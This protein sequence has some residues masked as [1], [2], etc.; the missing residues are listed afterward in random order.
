MKKKKSGLTEAKA[1]VNVEAGVSVPTDKNGTQIN[2]GDKVKI[3]NSK[4]DISEIGIVEF[5]EGELK[6]KH[7]NGKYS[8]VKIWL[9][10]IWWRNDEPENFIEVL[11]H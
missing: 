11:A 2:I 6:I 7:E 1:K 9:N 4:K 10:A 8:T 3:E 5:G